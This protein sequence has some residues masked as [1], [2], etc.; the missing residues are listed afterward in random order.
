MNWLE[1]GFELMILDIL[2]VIDLIS[3][4]MI[5]NMM[6]GFYCIGNNNKII[7]GIVIYIVIFKDKK[8]YMFILCKDVKWSNGDFVIV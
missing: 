4:N 5:N 7:L 1:N 8:I 2:L 3:V 6:E